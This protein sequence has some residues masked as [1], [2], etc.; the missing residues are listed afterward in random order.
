MRCLFIAL[1]TL[2]PITA[3]ADDPC[4]NNGEDRVIV[5]TA[6][7][8]TLMVLPDG[9]KVPIGPYSLC[10]ITVWEERKPGPATCF[11]AGDLFISYSI[12]DDS[13]E[14]CYSGGDWK[15][16]SEPTLAV[17]LGS[18]LDIGDFISTTY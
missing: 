3:G 14:K 2:L 17:L 15:P 16:M 7:N 6:D 13:W 11:I 18:L 1:L 10:P 12:E 4:L 9:R 8:D 5:I